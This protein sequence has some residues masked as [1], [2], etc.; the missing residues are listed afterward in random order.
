MR[1]KLQSWLSL[2]SF[3]DED[4]DRNIRV[5]NL[6]V[7]SGIPIAIILAISLLAFTDLW[8]GPL[9]GLG[10]SLI[11]IGLSALLRRGHLTLVG[12]LLIWSSFVAGGVTAFTT[13]GIRDTSLTTLYLFLRRPNLY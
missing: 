5:L 9:I 8:I 1:H 2:P 3:G 13:N 11:L 4:L 7:L 10:M 12:N 6:I